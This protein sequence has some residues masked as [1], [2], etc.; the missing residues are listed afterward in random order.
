M[1][2]YDEE[3]LGQ[4]LDFSSLP[5]VAQ[6]FVLQESSRNLEQNKSLTLYLLKPGLQSLGKIRISG[7]FNYESYLWYGS[8][9][10]ILKPRYNC[11]LRI[12]TAIW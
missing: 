7:Y 3:Q 1:D 2:E 10:N 6:Q 9:F 4:P 12:R 8:P 5:Q 11:S